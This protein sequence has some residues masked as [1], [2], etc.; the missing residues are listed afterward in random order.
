MGAMKRRR[1]SARPPRRSGREQRVAGRRRRRAGGRVGAGRTPSRPSPQ[2]R[3]WRR[4]TISMPRSVRNGSTVSMTSVCRAISS[5]RPPVAIT[6]HFSPSSAQMACTMPSTS[7][8][9]PYTAPDCSASVVDLPMACS[10]SIEL[11]LD[12]LGGARRERLERDLDAGG[13]G[14]AQ[15]VALGGDDVERGGRAVVGD[16]ARPAVRLE[17]G[18]G[19]DDAVGADLAPGSSCRCACRS[20]R[21]G[22]TTNASMPR[23]FSH[24]STHCC[25]SRGT[26]E[27]MP[28]SS[29]ASR[30]SRALAA[31]RSPA[32][33][34][35]SRRWCG[36][37]RWPCATRRPR[38][39]RPSGRCGSACCPTST[40]SST[41]R[42]PGRGPRSIQGA[43]VVSAPTEMTSTPA[44][45][46]SRTRSSAHAAGDLDDGAAG[47]ARDGRRA[48]WPCPCCRAARWSR[49][50]ASASSSCSSVSTS[51]SSACRCA[52]PART[53]R[54]GGGARRRPRATWLSLIIAPSNRPKRCGVPPPCTTACFSRARRPGVVLRVAAMRAFGAGGL[55]DVAA[56]SASPRRSGRQR[57]LSAVRSAARIAASGPRSSASD[58]AGGEAL[59]VARSDRH[60]ER[61]VDQPRRLLEARRR[62]RAR[63]P[64]APTTRAAPSPAKTD[65][66]RSP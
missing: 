36:A 59:A 42:P 66:V 29:I 58:V 40:T 34:R 26:T 3:C 45:A 64:R 44:S 30:K 27:A 21:P 8:A 10:G 13:D 9:N 37:A 4:M 55:G 65:P 22:P 38:R 19:V 31:R 24:I 51:T 35:R 16:D 54:D 33:A 6:G 60:V 53:Q 39:R 46:S 5:A 43:R 23:C 7:P 52:A 62:R 41:V 14:A 47:D 49:P 15:V 63:R 48:P 11:D 57:K 2:A 18:D 17:G 50:Q 32:A 25:V 56:P 20:A 12:E 28:T 61:R 1:S